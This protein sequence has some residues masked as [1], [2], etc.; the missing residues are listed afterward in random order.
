MPN[1][2]AAIGG[3]LLA[4][5]G[6]AIVEDGKAKRE[7]ALAELERQFRSSEA[8]KGR[9]HAT[10]LMREQQD[11]TSKREGASQAA[12]T[13]R[14]KLDITGREEVAKI[15]AKSRKEV[16]D[17]KIDG[18]LEALRAQTAAKV[19]E[20]MRKGESNEQVQR[21][22]NEGD[23][24]EAR[25]RAGATVEAATVGAKSREAVAT[26]RDT[27]A[28]TRTTATI[29]G[30]ATDLGTKNDFQLKLEASRIAARKDQTDAD[31]AERGRIADELNKRGITVAGI[32]AAAAQARTE[33][34]AAAKVATGPG[35][36]VK[37]EQSAEEQDA[38]RRKAEER[39]EKMA[40]ARAGTFRSDKTDFPETD[41]DR[42]TWIE[43]MT[44]QIL[45]DEYG[46]PAP[47][48]RPRL[49]ATPTAKPAAKVLLSGVP[50]KPQDRD[51][52]AA[53]PLKANRAM[54]RDQLI[55]GQV[56]D[57][58]KGGL[59]RWN[60]SSFDKAK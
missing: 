18:R 4:G 28:T 8:E 29:A 16:E 22:K 56:Y 5:V 31:R 15:G 27:G 60:G 36:K 26:I 17:A 43:W 48:G 6:Q 49:T 39:A 52:P 13:E 33:T 58:G 30:R 35:A 46:I 2:L 7:L 32:N 37:A 25:I 40:E 41:G 23:A 34:T 59:F 50:E 24:A 45:A 53:L 55:K 20:A 3:G 42:Q 51:R 54:D 9:T 14:T 12:Q 19:Q 21:I 44:D 47:Q 1:A 38:A 11:L 57:D 10:G